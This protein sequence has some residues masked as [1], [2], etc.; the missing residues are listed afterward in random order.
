[1]K[2]QTRNA[3][4]SDRYMPAHYG[5]SGRVDPLASVHHNDGRACRGPVRSVQTAVLVDNLDSRQRFNDEMRPRVSLTAL[6]LEHADAAAWP[7]TTDHGIGL[8]DVR[9]PE[10]TRPRP[11]V[12]QLDWSGLERIRA[13]RARM[14]ARFDRKTYVPGV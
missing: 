5:R 4:G 2:R 11:E 7:G 12:R 6:W 3:D 1:M 13:I 10:P 14:A 9:P 8:H